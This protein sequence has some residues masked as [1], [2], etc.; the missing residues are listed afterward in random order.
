[1]IAYVRGR[2]FYND[3]TDDKLDGASV[4]EVRKGEMKHFER[5]DMCKKVPYAQ[6]AERTCPKL[7]GIKWVHAFSC[8]PRCRLSYPCRSPFISP[9]ALLVRLRLVFNIRLCVCYFVFLGL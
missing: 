9:F 1:M 4:E 6:G 8:C 5:M 7:K 3:I 2:E